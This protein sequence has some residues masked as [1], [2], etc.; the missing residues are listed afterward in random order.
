MVMGEEMYE[1]DFLEEYSVYNEKLKQL[2]NN[3]VSLTDDMYR[4]FRDLNSFIAE[5]K[6]LISKFF[7]SVTK[8]Y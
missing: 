4:V 7:L 3:K 8:S 6:D 5:F 1:H 2:R